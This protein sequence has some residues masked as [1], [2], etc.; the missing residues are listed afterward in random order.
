VCKTKKNIDLFLKGSGSRQDLPVQQQLQIA[1]RISC[2]VV[3]QGACVP[4]ANK[5]GDVQ[6]LISWLLQFDP[7]AMTRFNLNY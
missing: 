1:T 4:A 3:A 2:P 7:K 6:D 5:T